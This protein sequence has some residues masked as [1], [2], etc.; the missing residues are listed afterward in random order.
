ME[1]RV[2]AQPL[3]GR[4]IALLETREAE[5][6]V[7]MF[8]EQG[9][10]VVSHR[11]VA[12]V[13]AADPAPV[14]D[15]LTRFVAG[16]PDYLVLLTGEGL[17]RLHGLAAGSGME[18]DFVAKLAGVATITRGPKPARALRSLGLSPGLRTAEPTTEGIIAV[19]SGIDLQGRRVGVQLYP[20]AP[21]RLCDYLKSAG[22]RPDAVTPY[23]YA[24]CEPDEALAG[25]IDQVVAGEIDAIAFTSA[26]QVRRLFDVARAGARVDALTAALRQTAVVAVGPVVASEL[27]QRGAAPTIVPAN[28]Y[29]M[30]P[31]VTAVV[32]CLTDTGRQTHRLR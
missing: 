28:Q 23:E 29:F 9:A 19:L 15:W 22:A 20:E 10:T 21:S 12:I 30:K 14:L 11:T 2:E 17:T 25:L 5:R 18:A 8:R 31:L 26:S 3:T 24:P 7:Q 27:Q 32:E 4:R 6:L 13:D 1:D 16:P